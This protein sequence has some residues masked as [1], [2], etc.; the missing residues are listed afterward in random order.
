MVWQ[1][2]GP[3]CCHGGGGGGGGGEEDTCSSSHFFAG[4]KCTVIE[5]IN[6]SC[7]GAER[8][9]WIKRV[10]KPPGAAAG[11]G[12]EGMTG[13]IGETGGGSLALIPGR[14]KGGGTGIVA[15]RGEEGGREEENGK[16]GGVINGR[17]GGRYI[18]EERIDIFCVPFLRERNG[19]HRD[20]S[21]SR[22]R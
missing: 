21:R 12:K 3:F 16:F 13:M 18:M 17:F 20:R 15:G 14:G 11:I 9:S 10:P 22:S 4:D 19:R 7:P 2:L 8:E 5:I 6:L 1:L